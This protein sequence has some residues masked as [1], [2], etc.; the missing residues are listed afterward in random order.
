MDVQTRLPL[1]KSEAFS[2]PVCC[3]TNH[4]G[5]GGG[6]V[7][8]GVRPPVPLQARLL[9][10]FHSISRAGVARGRATPKTTLLMPHLVSDGEHD[11]EVKGRAE[12]GARERLGVCV[13][14]QHVVEELAVGC[15]LR[16]III[17]ITP[18]AA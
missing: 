2:A 7:R 9:L 13:V 18:E 16:A 3:A 14:A 5:I 17:A 12:G 8:I 1:S 10:T 15:G 6:M 11:V 4:D